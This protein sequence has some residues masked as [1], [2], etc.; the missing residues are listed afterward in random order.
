[1]PLLHGDIRFARS[2]RMVDKPEGGGPPSA[3]LLT[4]GRSNE[5][6]PDIS[7]ETRTVGRVEIYS[8]FGVLRN[9]DATPLLGANVIIAEPPAD[10]NVSIAILTLKNPAATRADIVKRIESGMNAASEFSGYLLEDHWATM[11]NITILQRPEGTPPAIGRTYILVLNEG[12]A[13][14]R[15]QRVRIK[16]TGSEIKRFTDMSATP[17]VEFD[18]RQT[19]C[20]LFDLLSSDFP[21]SPPSRNFTR[22]S[23]RTKIRETM[24]SDAGL[25]YSASRLTKATTMVDN[26]IETE[27]IYVQ[28]V[29]NS[30][31]EAF[32]TDQRPA[33]KL[34]VPLASAPRQ[35]EAAITPHTKRIKIAEENAKTLQLAELRPLP[36]PGTVFIDYWALGQLY[37]I[38][39]DGTGKLTGSGSGTV[40]YLTGTVNIT[41]KAIPDIG[42]SI[43]ITWGSAVAYTNRSGQATV[44]EFTYPWQIEA[45]V[46][47]KQVIPG[48][49]VIKY[50]SSN[51]VRTVTDD[52]NGNLV[53]D[54]TGVIDYPS[55]EILLRP[56]YM[57]DSGAQ[58]QVDCDL[59]NVVT[60]LFPSP[61][62]NA[63][64]QAHFTLQQQPAAKSLLITWVTARSTSNTSGGS[65]DQ[66]STVK[67]TDRTHVVLY[68]PDGFVQPV[69]DGVIDAGP[70]ITWTNAGNGYAG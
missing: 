61:S 20:E 39:D 35:V 47:T 52:G 37:R 68:R 64:G 4:S 25:F 40:N 41:L 46:P 67:K 11:N 32:T 53:G 62:V 13:S 15:R 56:T 59:D 31:G 50:P 8:I 51:I 26:W 27:S 16:A 12:Q 22:V 28:L 43:A 18:A 70:P 42:S 2:Q 33:A 10:P 24:Y 63:A 3:Q 69:P 34:T 57:P 1:M 45:D 6:F 19:V 44:R 30:T 9:A 14:E 60:E 38:Y 17:P 7:E 23:N 5:I 65:V 54:A 48:S 21:G 36:A 55:R 49:L 58:F 66:S 29:P